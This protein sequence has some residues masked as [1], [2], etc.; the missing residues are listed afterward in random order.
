MAGADCASAARSAVN[1]SRNS[2][3]LALI[4]GPIAEGQAGEPCHAHSVCVHCP[5]IFP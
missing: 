2:S 4:I 1:A 5:R 3:S